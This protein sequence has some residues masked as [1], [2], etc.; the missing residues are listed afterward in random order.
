MLTTSSVHRVRADKGTHPARHL[1]STTFW[2]KTIC[3]TQALLTTARKKKEGTK[4]TAL[5]G[6]RTKSFLK[7]QVH[8]PTTQKSP[9]AI[10][11]AKGRYLDRSGTQAVR[12]S[13]R[14]VRQVQH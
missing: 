12:S 7:L 8:A 14:I 13:T 1:G 11:A 5:V 3:L 4:A 6:N 2:L 9:P 10:R